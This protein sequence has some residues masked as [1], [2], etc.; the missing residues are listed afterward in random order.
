MIAIL[1]STRRSPSGPGFFVG[2]ASQARVC[3]PSWAASRAP[4]QCS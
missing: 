3:S 1:L 4:H 2:L